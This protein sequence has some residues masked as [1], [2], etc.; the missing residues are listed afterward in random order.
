MEESAEEQVEGGHPR[1]APERGL[2][3]Y[4]ALAGA[5]VLAI[6]VGAYLFVSSG[7]DEGVVP[8]LPASVGTP[9]PNTGPL[10]PNRPKEGE[11]APDFALPDAR[12]PGRLVKLSDFRGRPVVLNF[13]YSTCDPCKREI[14]T[15]VRAGS[16]LGES[17]V[18]LGVD[19]LE[20]QED[21]VSILDKY[22]AEYPAVLDRSGAV[23]EHYR[24]Q[25]YPTTFFIDEA[26]ILRAIRSGEVH[27]DRLAELLETVGVDY[28][29]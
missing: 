13:Y 2:L 23:A 6:G 11:V 17:V 26:G 14:P 12:N 4:V 21:A 8:V 15:F 7:E 19:W 28:S 29:P 10:D 24:V 3:G 5:L 20:G 22:G 9:Q 16:A 1:R 27:E 18:F 25:G